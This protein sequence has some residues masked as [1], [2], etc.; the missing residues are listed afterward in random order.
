[1]LALL[2]LPLAPPWTITPLA[3]IDCRPEPLL[4]IEGHDPSSTHGVVP[5]AVAL[6]PVKVISPVVE[7][8]CVVPPELFPMPTLLLPATVPPR[9]VID[10]DCV[11]APA[12]ML[13]APPLANIPDIP[14]E[15]VL[16][17]T[18]AFPPLLVPVRLIVCAPWELIIA[19]P[20]SPITLRLFELVSVM[21]CEVPLL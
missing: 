20:A 8:V 12:V 13:C 17:T 10:P 9:T 19:P 4:L 14:E 15:D 1:M 18:I 5:V 7:I 16:P 6:P 11:G 21:F 2:W 3:V